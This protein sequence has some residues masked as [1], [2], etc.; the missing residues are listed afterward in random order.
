MKQTYLGTNKSRVEN[1]NSLFLYDSADSHIH[2][3]DPK[4]SSL[5]TPLT[6]PSEAEEL[7]WLC[8]MF[9]QHVPE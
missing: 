4:L 6:P 5:G 2:M 9:C 8:C 3:H 1:A 7:G